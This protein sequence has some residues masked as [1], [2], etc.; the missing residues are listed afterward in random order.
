MADSINLLGVV[1]T[2]VAVFLAI[3]ALLGLLPAYILYKRSRTEKARA[4]SLVDDPS[5]RFVSAFRI[6]GTAIRPKI[7]IPDLRS[8]PDWATLQDAVL[9]NKPVSKSLG[10]RQ[11]RTSW[12][13]V[14][15]LMVAVF[16]GLKSGGSELLVFEGG[17]SY[18][19]VHAAWLL[20]LCIL[21]R[22]CVR[23]DHGLPLG[24]GAETGPAA[25]IPEPQL[26][27]LSGYIDFSEGGTDVSFEMH[28]LSTLQQSLQHDHLSLQTLVLLFTGYVGT[29]RHGTL[30]R[31]RIGDVDTVTVGLSR[32]TE[33]DIA[34][35]KTS[36]A[37]QAVLEVLPG[38][39]LSRTTAKL[40]LKR[41]FHPDREKVEETENGLI[42]KGY[43][44]VGDWPPSK[45]MQRRQGVV[46]DVWM[47]KKEAYLFGFVYL[48]PR[49]SRHGFLFDSKD[50]IIVRNVFKRD[51]P[52]DT[53]ALAKQW[54]SKVGITA[55]LQGRVR[56]H[57][58][59]MDNESYFVGPTWSR[60]I[61]QSL[62]SL[63]EA[64]CEAFDVESMMWKSVR[65][66]YVC[67][68][69]FRQSMEAYLERARAKEEEEYPGIRFDSARGLIS[70]PGDGDAHLEE[71]E[72][73]FDFGYILS[74]TE[75]ESSNSSRGSNNLV[76][77][78]DIK[79][80][81]AIFAGF[82][83]QLRA[84][85]WQM[86]LP[87]KDIERLSF[88]RYDNAC[89]VSPLA[90]QRKPR[91]T[92]SEDSRRSYDTEG[93]NTSRERTQESS[94]ESSRESSQGSYHESEEESAEVILREILRTIRRIGL[95]NDTA[96]FPTRSR[97]AVRDAT[98]ALGRIGLPPHRIN[99]DEESGIGMLPPSASLGYSTP[100][101][102]R[103][104]M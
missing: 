48:D 57:L 30:L 20:A 17:Q 3:V 60:Q 80:A 52:A 15:Q 24:E 75:P 82:H 63:D 5:R 99:I 91:R 89:R 70:V 64:I 73:A 35:V 36:W 43:Y 28:A 44:K 76:V 14:S 10:P 21:H 84:L 46:F 77:D 54:L 74:N 66:L 58:E 25:A 88:M 41:R 98:A 19:T 93:S 33:R 78:G 69:H 4:L 38:V 85:A 53:L 103:H 104:S 45:R 72:F 6:F 7:E 56:E 50:D 22:F 62:A 18:L 96:L 9:E 81:H 29:R 94:R 31:G 23:P 40:Q 26:S 102:S 68:T 95:E 8:P 27:G 16:P 13:Q 92:S 34:I 90:L 42:R 11:S 32:G 55:E 39:S 51:N 67:N 100:H 83:G 79:P 1:G 101:Q 37:P 87:P 65:V 71:T 97:G 2:W 86:S 49:P 61:M 59:A 12:I 47:L